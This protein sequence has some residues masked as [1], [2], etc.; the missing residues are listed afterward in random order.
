VEL[1]AQAPMALPRI[2]TLVYSLPAPSDRRHC[3]FTAA[4]GARVVFN[5]TV[6]AIFL[7][8]AFTFYWLA[9]PRLRNPI[10]LVASY[11]F[12][13][14]WDWRF[15][16]LLALSTVVDFTIGIRMGR[17]E[18]ERR[19]KQL[20]ILSATVNLGILGLFKYFNFFVDTF[21]EMG[22]ALGFGAANPALNVVLPV[23]ISFYTFQTLSYSFDVYRRRIE[24]TRNIIDFGTYVAYFPQLVAGPIE[25]A[26]RLLPQIQSRVRPLPVGGRLYSAAALILQGLFK[27]VVIADGVASVANTVFADPTGFSWLANITGVVAFAI[28]IYGDFSGYTDIARGVSMLFGIDL[29]VNFR[30]PYLSRNITEFWRRWHISLSDW[31]RDY[32]YIPLGGNRGSDLE[33][34]RNLMITMLLGGLWHG[35]SWNFVVWGALHGVYLIVHKLTRGGKVSTAPVAWRDVPAILVT[36]AFVCFAWVF[37]RAETFA[38]AFDVLEAV[39]TLQAGATVPS[40][41]LLVAVIGAVTLAVDLFERR[42]FDSVEL[43]RRSPAAVGASVAAAVSAIVVFSGGTP[44]PFIY[45]QF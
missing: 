43:V 9:P 26:Q 42:E 21:A 36:F 17:T 16:G 14:Y 1:D 29:V 38:N 27:K 13:G 40:D 31:L 34:Y 32:L 23:G 33:T 35:A 11:I 15:L 28:Q 44:E 4:E 20:L 25:R 22:E 7:V 5:S 41:L 19:R 24:P 39:F 12:Y 45:F 37:F 10:L 3:L 30:Q 18:V 2:G 8:V 6:F